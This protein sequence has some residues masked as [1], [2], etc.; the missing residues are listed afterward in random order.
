MIKHLG[1]LLVAD[2]EA[3]PLNAR[4]MKRIL[5]RVRPEYDGILERFS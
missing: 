2:D 3:E 5:E 1:K 4:M